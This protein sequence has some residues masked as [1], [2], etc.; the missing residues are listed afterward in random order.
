MGRE[1][2]CT[3]SISRALEILLMADSITETSEDKDVKAFQ[4]KTLW[5]TYM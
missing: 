3:D 5:A 2:A 1:Y 4:S